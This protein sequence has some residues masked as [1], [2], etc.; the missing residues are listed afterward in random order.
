VRAVP[1]LA[2]FGL[3]LVVPAIA[4]ADARDADPVPRALDLLHDGRFD[5]AEALVSEAAARDPRNPE[6]AFFRGFVTY[7]RLLYDPEDSAQQVEF[8]RR[9]GRTIA[10]A[11]AA[12]ARGDG[13][14]GRVS[15]WKGSAHLLMAQL[16]AS[17]RKP[18]GAAFEAKKAKRLLEGAVAAQSPPPDSDF[19]IGTYQYYAD[20]VPT[21]VK[22]LRALLFIPGGDREEGLARLERSARHSRFFGLEARVLLATIYADDREGLYDV[23]LDH[24]RIALQ[25]HPDSIVVLHGAARLDLSLNRPERARALLERALREADERPGVDPDVVATLRYYAAR[26]ELESFRPD[27]ALERVRPILEAP[28]GLPEEVVR[29]SRAIAREAASL[30]PAGLPRWAEAAGIELPTLSPAERAR[31]VAAA[32]TLAIA[33]D[34]LSAERDG[35]FGEAAAA[36]DA[37]ARERPDDP[38]AALLAGRGALLAGRAPDAAAWLARADRDPGLP[39]RL[40]ATARM[41]AGM[42]EDLRGQ[43]SA[44]LAWYA[45]AEATDG[46]SGKDAVRLLRGRAFAPADLPSAR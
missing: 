23:A 20:Q 21:L 31:R 42:A 18:F 8:E 40:R 10:V 14:P 26:A 46:F 43:R 32:A 13:D 4:L 28:A 37:L 1:I 2:I 45:R 19:G 17:Q 36:L 38:V 29:R 30:S 33:R 25:E 39:E 9:L 41:L 34:A 3:V 6:L 22:G 44:A 16:R 27:R 24:A 5:A 12:L 35:R 11:D 7:W 15:L